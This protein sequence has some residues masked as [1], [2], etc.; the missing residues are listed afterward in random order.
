MHPGFCHPF[1]QGGG[2]SRIHGTDIPPT[3]PSRPTYIPP[4]S[5]LH[6]AYMLLTSACILPTSR[7][8]GGSLYRIC[9]KG[10]GVRAPTSAFVRPRPPG[11][12]QDWDPAL[13]Q[14]C[15]LLA[16]P[17]GATAASL[18]A[19]GYAH[20]AAAG[21]TFRCHPGLIPPT[22]PSRPTYIPVSSHL[23]P[24]LIPCASRRDLPPV[25]TEPCHAPCR[26]PFA[27]RRQSL[28]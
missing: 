17:T 1:G 5:H 19:T 21:P 14:N 25:L 22:S 3:S 4:T 23:Y 11:R 16:H 7:C 10:F 20:R 2:A 13:W 28:L 27:P 18:L 6:P 9:R 12:P 26:E 24:G 15:G 8:G